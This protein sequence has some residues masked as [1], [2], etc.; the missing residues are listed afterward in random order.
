VDTKKE[1]RLLGPAFDHSPAPTTILDN[2]FK[3]LKAN[4]RIAE[5]F[6]LKP[7]DLIGRTCH[8]LIWGRER[9][10]PSCPKLALLRSEGRPAPEALDSRSAGRFICRVAPLS[11]DRG[12]IIGSVH[13]LIDTTE[14]LPQARVSQNAE[15]EYRALFDQAPIGIFQTNFEG[16]VISA[17]NECA[18]IFGYEN[19][20]ELVNGIHDIAKQ[21]YTNSKTRS[22]LIDMIVNKGPVRDF[23]IS[24]YRKDG[25]AFWAKLNAQAA[26]HPDGSVRCFEG[27]IEDVTEKM[28]SAAALTES[29][30]KYR[31]LCELLPEI[32]FEID[33][34]LT[35]TFI[36][37]SGLDSL[38]LQYGQSLAG[39]NPARFLSGQDMKKSSL[40]LQELR[41]GKSIKAREYVVRTPMGGRIPVLV[42]CNPII[43]DGVFK[44]FRGLAIDIS[45][46]KEA[47]ETLRRSRA[48]LEALVASRTAELSQLNR[49]LLTEIEYRKNAEKKSKHVQGLLKMVFD[50]SGDSLYMKDLSLKYTIVNPQMERLL[51]LNSAQI[52]GQSDYDL[53]DRRT[54]DHLR[55]LEE[56]VLG[57]EF[58]ETENTRTIYGEV[59]TLLETRMPLRDRNGAIKGL[60][61]ISR[62]IGLLKRKNAGA[63]Q[64]VYDFRSPS[65]QTVMLSAQLAS[66]N[67]ST[68]LLLG[69]S[70]V[71]KDYV[72]KY[73]HDHSKRSGGPF[74]S[75]NCAA[76]SPELAESELFGHEAGAFT[77]ATRLKR[78]MLEFAEGGTLLLN[79]IGELPSKLQSKLL[80]FLDTKALSRVGGEKLIRVN[81]RLIAATNRNL[82]FEVSSGTFR[83]DLFYRLNVFSIEIPP[84]RERS[85]DIP[86]LIQGILESLAAEMQLEQ[87]P[88]VT[89]EGLEELVRYKWPGNVREVRN[90]L[91]RAIILSGNCVIDLPH[92]GLVQDSGK[93]SPEGLSSCS[94]HSLPEEVSAL[95]KKLIVEALEKTRG[96]KKKAAALLGINRHSLF[97][98]MRKL[99]ID[100]WDDARN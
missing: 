93:R 8:S 97:R 86:L 79:E 16:A 58:L 43:S 78:G 87:V 77:G 68:V 31:E 14:T 52:I 17:N 30:A 61:G 63:A 71:G 57:G 99:G 11:D 24:F 44:G 64:P 94:G 82:D 10:I 25:S 80:T 36:N 75:L 35:L 65:M 15:S 53:F 51:G 38:G 7:E 83:K 41:V 22:Q 76:I 3:I 85:E 6:N 28:I 42:N 62:D 34:D 91:E 1:L 13:V 23:E 60:C 96:N 9:P 32:V 26:F 21:L 90:I 45:M 40:D 70:G 69:E 89:P 27:F 73:I 33:Q 54:A 48:Q 74:Y 88:T 39:L 49:D 29:E 59:V 5:L 20:T 12:R 72:A 37:R 67:D 4:N 84:L 50:H 98:L 56:R 18:R 46:Q 92:L 100:L 55:T 95:E 66:A 2:D 19:P 47:S 81:A